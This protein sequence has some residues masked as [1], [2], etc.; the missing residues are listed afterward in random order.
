MPEKQQKQQLDAFLAS[1]LLDEA[2]R[3]FGMLE[4]TTVVDPAVDDEFRELL[5]VTAR[6]LLDDVAYLTPLA[7]TAPDFPSWRRGPSES[8]PDEL[9]P[10]ICRAVEA[11][12][13]Y[14]RRLGAIA[15]VL[16]NQGGPAAA[17]FSGLA[18]AAEA[19]MTFLAS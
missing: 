12:D 18:E 8:L 14:T 3:V 6:D 16:T 10:L 19:R 4:A 1:G 11:L 13:A 2:L 17:V 7:A 9:Q 5:G 15:I